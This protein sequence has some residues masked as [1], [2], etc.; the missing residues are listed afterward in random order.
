MPQSWTS[1][2]L[3]VLLEPK[4]ITPSFVAVVL[5]NGYPSVC[6]RTSTKKRVLVAGF[7]VP[8]FFQKMS[9]DSL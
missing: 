9:F 1:R 2:R 6:L 5:V 7:S 8:K 4:N 3:K